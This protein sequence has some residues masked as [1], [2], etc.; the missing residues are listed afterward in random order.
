MEFSSTIVTELLH[1][2][3]SWLNPELIHLVRFDDVDYTGLNAREKGERANPF[4]GPPLLTVP[5]P[6][7]AT[8]DTRAYGM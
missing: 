3:Q 1:P 2:V 6:Q 8:L 4:A 7:G 5:V